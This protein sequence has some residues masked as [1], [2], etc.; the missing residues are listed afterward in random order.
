MNSL[1][2]LYEEQLVGTL[3]YDINSDIFDFTY[4]ELWITK[5]FELSPKL[6]F[7]QNISSKTIK[8]FLENLLP[9]GD[10][11]E[12]LSLKYHISKNNIFALVKLIGAETTG[13]L[14][15]GSL[16]ALHQTSFCKIDESEMAQRIKD[17]KSN[18]ISIWDGKVRLSVAGVQDKLPIT[19]IGDEFGFGEGTLASTHILKFDKNDE[20]L[21]LNEFI[22]LSLARLCGLDTAQIEIKNY[23]DQEVLCIKRFDRE[24]IDNKTIKRKHII[25]ACQALDLSVLEKYERVFGSSEDVKDYRQGASFEKI[26]SLISLCD[27]PILVKKSLLTWFCVNLCLG[28]SDAHGKN[29]SF[30]IEK[31][32]IKLAPFYDIL[33]ISLYEGKYE[34]NFAFGINDAFSYEELSAYELIEFCKLLDI[35]L[36]GLVKEFIRVS[37]IIFKALDEDVLTFS[38]QEKIDF[39]DLY[40]KNT[41]DRIVY[42]KS[43]FDYALEYKKR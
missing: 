16:E 39:Y 23:E 11:R 42:L 10:G 17:R 7:N 1:D 29:I 30:L 35:S 27:S 37:N 6:P 3:S 38:K 14:H 24:F 21:V 32:S 20:N 18:P 9:E 28:N 8:N 12:L 22:S 43:I 15:F 40:K 31:D 13:A 36:K 4:D 34:T 5:G 2:I 19:Y 33:N 41:L 26:F 25:D